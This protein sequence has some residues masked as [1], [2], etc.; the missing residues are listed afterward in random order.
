MWD[1]DETFYLTASKLLT[2]G[3]KQKCGCYFLLKKNHNIVIKL[4]MLFCISILFWLLFQVILPV[5]RFCC[6]F[7]LALGDEGSEKFTEQ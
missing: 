1:T 5:P 3:S 6:C 7:S 4:H 2:Q